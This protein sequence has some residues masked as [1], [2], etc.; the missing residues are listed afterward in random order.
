MQVL[1]AATIPLRDEQE[2]LGLEII[3]RIIADS[4]VM[5]S[6]IRCMT[7][8]H[9]LQMAVGPCNTMGT[10]LSRSGVYAVLRKTLYH[11]VANGNL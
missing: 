6:I 4:I 11:T 8:P 1:A 7:R 2:A 5:R 9:L 10:C 3:T